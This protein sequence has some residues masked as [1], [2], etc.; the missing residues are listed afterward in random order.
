MT[1]RSGM[2]PLLTPVGYSSGLPEIAE[3]IR[4]TT[5]FLSRSVET[6]DPH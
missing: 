5:V 1:S 3:A 6:N 4:F 2:E